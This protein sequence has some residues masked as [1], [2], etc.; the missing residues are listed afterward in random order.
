MKEEIVRPIEELY[1]IRRTVARLMIPFTQLFALY[2]IMH[3]EGG[4]GGGF[5]GGVILGASIILFVIVFGMEEGRKRISEKLNIFLVSLGVVIYSG[6]GLFCMLIGGNY[7]E[8]NILPLG[9]PHHAS[10]LGIL[11]IEIGIGITVSAVMT[12]IFFNTAARSRK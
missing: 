12:L 4:P 7:L 6:I 2:V 11:G 1:I 3:G 10:E 5:Q 8:Y 9:T